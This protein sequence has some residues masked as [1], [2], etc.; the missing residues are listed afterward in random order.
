MC[1]TGQPKITAQ[2]IL[3]SAS[4]ELRQEMKSAKDDS[5]FSEASSAIVGQYYASKKATTDV[6][7]ET[8]S[9]S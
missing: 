8:V 1:A 9:P 3:E 2:V 7:G 6:P 4:P 5:E